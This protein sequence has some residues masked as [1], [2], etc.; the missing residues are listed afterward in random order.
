[1][2]KWV[3]P[4]QIKECSQDGAEI[5]LTP[6]IAVKLASGWQ[7][8]IQDIDLCPIVGITGGQ[9]KLWLFRNTPVTIVVNVKSADGKEFKRMETIGLRN[10]REREWANLEYSMLLGLKQD[11]VDAKKAGDHATA[12]RTRQWMLAKRRP[13]SFGEQ[14]GVQVN[15]SSHTNIVNIDELG[16]PL[17]MRKQILCK[18]R[19]QKKLTGDKK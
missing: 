18:I 13:K 8:Q 4:Q 12:A 15:V 2:Q 5:T 17:E 9:L 10:L 6:D 7:V 3:T 14:P 16:L 11:I 1:M 19:E